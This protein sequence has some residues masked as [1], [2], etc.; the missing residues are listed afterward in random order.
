MK[1]LHNTI[2]KFYHT[3]GKTSLSQKNITYVKNYSSESFGTYAD[4]IEQLSSHSS[5]YGVS[6]WPCH[7]YKG[8]Y[9]AHVGQ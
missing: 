9:R 7:Q 1:S 4:S 5:F 3:V 8:I 6:L 2:R